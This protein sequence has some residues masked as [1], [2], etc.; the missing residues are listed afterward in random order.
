MSIQF[1]IEPVAECSLLVKFTQSNNTNN[2]DIDLSLPPKI[3][4]ICHDIT[5]NLMDVVMNITPSYNTILIDYLP[6]RISEQSLINVLNSQIKQMLAKTTETTVSRSIT[7]PCYYDP[8]VGYDI[9]KYTDSGISLERLIEIHASEVYTVCTIGF[10][11]GFAFMANVPEPIQRPRIDSP[12]QMVP[13][14][15]VGIAN[16]QTAV[17]PTD[18]PGGWNIIGNC[19]I[20]LVKDGTS[21][22]QIGDKITFSPISLDEFIELGG[23]LPQQNR[24]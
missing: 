11:P 16:N 18:S 3:G 17:Y 23:Q 7:L 22:L 12:R 13:K 5:E 24:N 9:K 8:S 20:D 14:G 4:A 6:I 15:S 19:P 2:K 21:Y 1:T 10:S